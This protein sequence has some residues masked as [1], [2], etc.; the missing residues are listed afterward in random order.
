ME[1]EAAT[2][3]EMV[4]PTAASSGDGVAPMEVD[5]G[6][7]CAGSA[8]GHGMGVEKQQA[9]MK[10][11]GSRAASTASLCNSHES[12]CVVMIFRVLIRSYPRLSNE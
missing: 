4:D 5:P 1:E 9:S 10:L 8:V 6:K 2:E 7:S 3:D 12:K 11:H